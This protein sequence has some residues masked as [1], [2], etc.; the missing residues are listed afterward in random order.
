MQF[1]IHKLVRF[2]RCIRHNP[3]VRKFHSFVINQLYISS[4]SSKEAYLYNFLYRDSK[5]SMSVIFKSIDAVYT[6]VFLFISGR[7]FFHVEKC[8]NYG[9]YYYH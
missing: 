5:R 9:L 7:Q 4:C 8:P 6:K 1:S 3:L 2:P